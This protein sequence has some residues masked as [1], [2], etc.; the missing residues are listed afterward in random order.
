MTVKY[1][2]DTYLTDIADS[3]RAKTGSSDPIALADMPDEID[4]IPSAA[5]R[6]VE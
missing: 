5:S 6:D 3:I 1:I 2:D 4:D